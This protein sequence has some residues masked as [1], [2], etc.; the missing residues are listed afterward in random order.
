V[1]RVTVAG[2]LAAKPANGGE[3]WVRLSYVLGL[4]RLRLDVSFV[5][6]VATTSAAATSWFRSVTE[7]LGGVA[8]LVNGDGHPLVGPD[9]EGGDLLLNLSGNLCSPNVLSRFSRTAFVDL[10]PGFTQAWHRDGAAPVGRHDVYF[11]VAGNIGRAGC[12]VPTGGIDWRP[13]L[14]PVALDEWPPVETPV[15]DRFTTVATWRPGHG[16]VVLAGLRHGLKLH[17]FRRVVD[18]PRRA[19][20][21][22]EVALAIDA[23]ESQDLALLRRHRWLLVD[24][25]RVAGDP[26]S[27]RAYVAGSGAEFSVAQGAYT[28]TSSGWFSDRTARYLASGRPALVQDTGCR[29]VPTGEGLLTFRGLDDAA[30][31]AHSIVNDYR[32]HCRAA[33]AL[34]AEYL[35]SD[36]V[37][38]RLLED[39]L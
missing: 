34:A 24:P 4:R 29:S 6:Q 35:D 18:L 28:A 13:T 14:P 32:R 37:L 22:F 38:T 15:F 26:S 11:T 3:A 25:T 33:R 12:S 16:D 31:G 9:P 19:R 1:T 17:Q 7:S 5:E 21:P 39:A 27:F 23:N 2:A 20:L 8:S 10:D 30:A 36:L